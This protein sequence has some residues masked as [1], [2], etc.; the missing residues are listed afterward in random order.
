LLWWQ[1]VAAGPIPWEAAISMVHHIHAF[2]IHVTVLILSLKGVPDYSRAPG[3]IPELRRLA[4]LPCD[5]PGR[6]GTCRFPSLDHVFLG[7]FWMYNS[8]SIVI[9]HFKFGN[10]RAMSGEPSIR[11][12]LFSTSPT[13][14][15]PKSA[16]TIM[17]GW[18]F[19]GPKAS[20]VINSYGLLLEVPNA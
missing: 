14:T 11:M 12:A 9:F 18:C 5:G 7:L 13:A 4:S 17:V 20:Q 16:I 8:I 15:S 2:T 1:G 10:A 19:S 3:F 6:G